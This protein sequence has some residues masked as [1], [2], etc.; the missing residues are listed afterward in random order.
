MSGDPISPQL[1]VYNTENDTIFIHDPTTC[2]VTGYLD[3]ANSSSIAN[4]VAVDFYANR[5]TAGFP[6][7]DTLRGRTFVFN[8]N[9]STG[10]FDPDY[11]IL[12]NPNITSFQF[13]GLTVPICG[14]GQAVLL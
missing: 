4:S 1:Y 14:G 10:I 2:A 3:I 5:I 9:T 8:K 6:Q 11:A 13:Q 12:N 7:L